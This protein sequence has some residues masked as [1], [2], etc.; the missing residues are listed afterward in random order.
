MKVKDLIRKLSALKD[1]AEYE[2]S[3]ESFL[4][5]KSEHIHVVIFDKEQTVVI[6]SSDLT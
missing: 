3:L 6:H 4:T 1:I 5:G 2:I